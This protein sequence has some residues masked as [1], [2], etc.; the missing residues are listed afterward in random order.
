MRVSARQEESNGER[1]AVKQKQYGL[2]ASREMRQQETVI[3]ASGQA[4]AGK[5]DEVKETRTSVVVQKQL[6]DVV[7]VPLHPRERPVSVRTESWGELTQGATDATT[8]P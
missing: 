8:L 2:E 3:D 6:H 4:E 1:A 5:S 7:L